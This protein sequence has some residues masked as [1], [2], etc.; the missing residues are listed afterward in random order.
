MPAHPFPLS[1]PSALPLCHTMLRMAVHGHG[2][3][4]L[5][6]I[7]P[8]DVQRLKGL[9]QHVVCP[10]P[11]SPPFKR[12]NRFP[13]PN[14]QL[15]RHSSTAPRRAY[16]LRALLS[17]HPPS[18]PC[19]LASLSSRSSLPD[20]VPPSPRPSSALPTSLLPARPFSQRVSSEAPL[21]SSCTA[22]RVQ[23]LLL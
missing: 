23:L 16:L 14:L 21:P 12:L 19:R 9:T 13:Y 20:F 3:P 8:F 1:S 5:S 22:L 17:K 2:N 11:P 15:P 4:V 6:A 10:L 7:W 18:P